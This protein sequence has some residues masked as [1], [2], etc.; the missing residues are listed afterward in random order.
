MKKI[1]K[2]IRRAIFVS[3]ILS[4]LVM[5]VGLPSIAFAQGVRADFNGDGFD[6]LAIGVLLEDVGSIVDAGA[7]NVIYGT[8]NL[9]SAANDQ[10]FTQNTTNIEDTAEASDNFG[11]ALTSGD[12]NGD[13]FDDLAIGVPLEDVGSIVDAG[14]VNV[15]YGTSGGL[16]TFNDQIFT[17]DT[18]DI[19]DK[20]TDTAEDRDQFGSALTSGD[21]NGDGFDDLAIGVG[22][23]DVDSIANAGAVNVI[24][25]TSGGLTVFNDQFFTQNTTNIEDTA[26]AND[27]FGATLA[28]GDFNGDGFDDLAIGVHGEDVGVG[29]VNAG[30][31]NVIYSGSG[32][33]SAISDQFFTQDTIDIEDTAEANDFFGRG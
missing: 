5:L 9:L 29:I 1:I 24:Y 32:G 23:E 31:V 7:V 30:A 28:S 8:A 25:G 2:T 19:V 11:F 3:V 4:I 18:T 33:L 21:F 20:I 15:I 17:Q 26:E 27:F 14:A 6:D 13:G 22:R 16:S 10:F 12:F